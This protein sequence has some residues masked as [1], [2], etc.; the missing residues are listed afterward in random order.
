VP[1]GSV[2]AIC[3]AKRESDLIPDA[4]SLTGRYLGLYQHAAKYWDKRYTTWTRTRWALPDKA[5]SGRTN[6]IV[7]IRMVHAAHGWRA[8]GWPV[9]DC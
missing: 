2:R 8:A 1:G 9:F 4:S 7:T 5:I 3:I 6:A